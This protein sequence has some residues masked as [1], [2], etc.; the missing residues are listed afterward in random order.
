M[1]SLGGEVVV[2]LEV[3]DLPGVCAFVEVTTSGGEEGVVDIEEVVDMSGVCALCGVTVSGAE[4]V[5]RPGV[6]ALVV[7]T[8][9]ASGVVVV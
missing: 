8:V 5:V 3:V 7:V 1:S 6:C 9:S 2:D 4:D